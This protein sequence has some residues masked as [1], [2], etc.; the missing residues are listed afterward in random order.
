M[1]RPSQATTARASMVGLRS[2]AIA[3][4]ALAVTLCFTTGCVT[5]KPDSRAP[6][7]GEGVREYERLVSGWR[8][9]VT[10]SRRAVEAL[11][12]EPLIDS[13][14][15]ATRFDHALQRLEVDSIQAR[16]RADALE[17]RGEA[18]FDEW[19]EEIS[20]AGDGASQQ[21]AQARFAELHEHFQRILQQSQ[22]LRQ[23]FRKFLEELRGLR[24]ELGPKPAPTAVL[25]LQEKLTVMAAHG[26]EVEAV[27]DRLITT[28]KAA[29]KA[30]MAGPAPRPKT[31]DSK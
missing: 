7:R 2:K 24:T 20:S 4:L 27:A 9:A 6:R 17:K 16:A 21:A 3:L 10:N 18:Y 13:T 25:H 23:D 11:A 29:E 19:A 1:M 5:A 15:T 28:L 12:V 30:V 14:T 8:K 31:G 26:R 22:Q